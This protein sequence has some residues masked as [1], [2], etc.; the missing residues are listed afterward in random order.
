MTGHRAALA[1]IGAA[2][3]GVE[4]RALEEWCDALAGAGVIVG[5][6]CG[7]EGLQMRGLIMRLHHLGL[8]VAMQGDMAAPPLGKGDAF[9]A[10]A[11]PGELATVTALLRVAKAAG[12][13]TLL[14]TAE[15]ARAPRALVDRLLTIPA[16]TMA[17][18][19][20]GQSVLPMGS[21]FEG[22]LFV[23]FEL[24]VAALADRLGETP[25]TMR[26]RHT[27]LE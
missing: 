16:R 12:A 11:G 4:A 18:G 9:L 21:V 23:L 22:A 17:Q 14:V 20:A 1:E 5:Y 2:L 8:R 15:P 3:D 26:A 6:G 25:E 10:S 13:T 24:L 7:R 19:E 27:N